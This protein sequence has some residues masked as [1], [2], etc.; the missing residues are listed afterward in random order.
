MKLTF[1]IDTDLMAEHFVS[2][3]IEA[4]MPLV[5]EDVTEETLRNKVAPKIQKY[6][7][8]LTHEE[9]ENLLFIGIAEKMFPRKE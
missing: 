5:R 4:V 1:E 6:F 3:S 8:R 7:D 9:I 2:K